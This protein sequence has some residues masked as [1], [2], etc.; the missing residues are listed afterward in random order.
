MPKVMG[1]FNRRVAQEVREMR[2]C[3]SWIRVAETLSI[4]EIYRRRVGEAEAVRGVAALALG[5]MLGGL[6]LLDRDHGGVCLLQHSGAC[7]GRRLSNS[8]E[9]E[10]GHRRRQCAIDTASRTNS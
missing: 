10:R 3:G 4:A 9:S 7:N 1:R 8:R 5:C 6:Q 2:D